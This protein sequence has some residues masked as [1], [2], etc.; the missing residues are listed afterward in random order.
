MDTFEAIYARRAI[1]QFDPNF[2]ISREDQRKLLEAAIQ[3]PTS[4]NVP[5]A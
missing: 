5:V 3:S 2:R 4:F 1:K